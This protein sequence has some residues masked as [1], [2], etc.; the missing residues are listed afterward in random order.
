MIVITA[1]TLDGRVADEPDLSAIAGLNS[2]FG[3]RL[4]LGPR[5]AGVDQ[6]QILVD[7]GAAALSVALVFTRG[8]RWSVGIGVGS[9]ARPLGESVQSGAGNAFVAAHAA[10]LRARKKPTHLA[11]VA[12]PQRQ[13]A[14]DA[15]ALIDLLL[16]LR[17]RRSA[18]GWEIRDLLTSGLSQAESA[19]RMGITPQSASKRARAAEIR[20]E[21]AA[22]PPLGRL[23][24][25]L[26]SVA[27]Q[28]ELPPMA[29]ATRSGSRG[30]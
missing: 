7:A 27:V 2:A 6:I 16:I 11:V 10:A 26:D 12:D 24:D 25:R 14:R 8:G 13:L 21:D 4:P 19:V 30:G 15:E 5:D 23:I 22:I 9:V 20:A 29:L 18:Q 17:A 1:N 28:R 3:D